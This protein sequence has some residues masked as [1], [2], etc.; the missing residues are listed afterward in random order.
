MNSGR[1]RP[2]RW[3]RPA[4]RIHPGGGA[5]LARQLLIGQDS[6]PH[7]TARSGGFASFLSNEKGRRQRRNECKPLQKGMRKLP[8]NEGGTFVYE[9]L[10]FLCTF[11]FRSFFSGKKEPKNLVLLKLAASSNHYQ[12]FGAYRFLCFRKFSVQACPRSTGASLEFPARYSLKQ[13]A[14]HLTRFSIVY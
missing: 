10:K 8:M 9:S 11:S 3:A 1:P 5:S 2:I 7:L 12:F 4:E 13:L 6:R 14:A